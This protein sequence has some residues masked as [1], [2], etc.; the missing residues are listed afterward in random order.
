MSISLS[1]ETDK[2]HLSPSS[3]SKKG[4]S[5]LSLSSSGQSPPA[6]R[7]QEEESKMIPTS[8]HEE[9]S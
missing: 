5:D 1:Q 9:G 2:I 7:V 4:D 8:T 3:A 6:S